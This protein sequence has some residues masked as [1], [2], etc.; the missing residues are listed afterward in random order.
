MKH[1]GNCRFCDIIGGQYRYT[2]IDEPIASNDEFVAVASIG[3][4]VE[5]W[6]LIIPKTH[7]LSMI[8][9]YRSSIFAD[10]VGSV[11]S[12]LNQQYGPLIAF[13]HGANK[14]GSMTGCGTDHA[15]LHLVPLGESL[16]TGLQ[17]SGLQWVQCHASEIASRSEEDEYLFYTELNNNE[18]WQDPVGYLHVL[19]DPSSQFFRRL[20]ANRRGGVE[21]T[22]YRRFP[23]LD[24]AMQTRSVLAGSVAIASL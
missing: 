7:Q 9:V 23:Y 1:S 4:L 19:E 12:P 24:T 10:F 18:V 6:T 21:V 2:G 14:D 16:L 13:E 11:L 17:S 22:D 20:I 8:N 3:A 5:G 15:H